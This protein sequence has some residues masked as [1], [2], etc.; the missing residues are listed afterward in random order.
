MRNFLLGV[1]LTL[2]VVFGGG[3]LYLATGG[4]NPSAQPPPGKFERSIAHLSLDSSVDRRAPKQQNPIQ[5][6]DENLIT[7][8]RM[9]EQ[10]CSECHGGAKHRTSE[11]GRTFSPRVPQIINRVPHDPD[12]NLFWITKNGIK[13]TGMPYWSNMLSDD[14]IWKVIAF[15]KHSDR[16]SPAVQEEWQKAAK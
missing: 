11:F 15:I 2:I 6:T 4:Y 13:M 16:L 12:A 7:G 8:A 9:Y 10:F 14:D 1:V 3:Y 5:P